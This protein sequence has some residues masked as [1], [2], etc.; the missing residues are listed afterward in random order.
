MDSK[1]LRQQLSK[2]QSWSRARLAAWCMGTGAVVT[3]VTVILS[4][5]DTIDQLDAIALALLAT[6][7]T[8]GGLIGM[9][10]PDAWT[11]WRRGFRQGCEAA[12]RSRYG[13]LEPEATKS[14]ALGPMPPREL[15]A[16]R[17]WRIEPPEVDAASA[18]GLRDYALAGT[19]QLGVPCRRRIVAAADRGV[20]LPAPRADVLDAKQG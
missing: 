16:R 5:N 3:L 4:F 11:A 7:I 2:T 9:T 12:V 1:S 14:G 19:T 8:L 6:T 17:G 18:V 15:A 10:V 13:A 20:P